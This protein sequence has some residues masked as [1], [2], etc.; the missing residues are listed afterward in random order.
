MTDDA[1]P[2]EAIAAMAAGLLAKNDN[3]KVRAARALLRQMRCQAR[4]R[5][6]DDDAHMM[7]RKYERLVYAEQRRQRNEAQCSRAA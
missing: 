7:I 1:L 4:N 3:D 5:P 2:D 6:D